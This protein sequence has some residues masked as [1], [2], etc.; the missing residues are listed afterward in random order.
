VG[1]APDVATIAVDGFRSIFPKLDQFRRNV[2]KRVRDVGYVETL[3]GKRR[4]L[5][6]IN[7]TDAKKR[8]KAERQALS[9][10]VQGT[11]ADQVKAAMIAAHEAFG[12]LPRGERPRLVLQLHDELIFEV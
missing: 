11:A 12:A 10:L 6:D 8:S 7:S 1:V 3:R 2:V 5:P 4:W 9:A